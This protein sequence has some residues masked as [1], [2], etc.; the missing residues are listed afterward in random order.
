MTMTMMMTMRLAGDMGRRV[1][2][3]PWWPSQEMMLSAVRTTTTTTSRSVIHP[4]TPYTNTKTPTSTTPN[5]SDTKVASTSAGV[6][7]RRYKE[8]ADPPPSPRDDVSHNRTAAHTTASV[9]LEHCTS[10]TIRRNPMTLLLLLSLLLVWMMGRV[11]HHYHHEITTHAANPPWTVFSVR[12]PR[13]VWLP[14]RNRPASHERLHQLRRPRGN[15]HYDPP[16]IT[17]DPYTAVANDPDDFPIVKYD[18]DD[19]D[20][21]DP[22]IQLIL[23]AQVSLIDLRLDLSELRKWDIHDDDE[24]DNNNDDDDDDHRTTNQ[25]YNGIYGTFCKINMTLYKHNPN[26][27]PMYNDLIRHSPECNLSDNDDDETSHGGLIRNINLRRIVNL[28]RQYDQGVDRKNS[29][30]Q[31]GPT[32]ANQNNHHHQNSRPEHGSSK[33][34]VLNVTSVIFH[35]SRC[36]STLL[37]NILTTMDIAKHR[38]YSEPRPILQAIQTICGEDFTVC[39][40][41]TATAILRDT[42]YIMSRSRRSTELVEERKDASAEEERVFFKFPSIASRNIPVFTKAFPNVPY[43]LLYRNPMEVMVSHFHP[44]VKDSSIRD[45]AVRSTANDIATTPNKPSP[46]IIK[47]LSQRHSPSVSVVDVVQKYNRHSHSNS[48]TSMTTNG[49]IVLAKALKDSDYCAAHL[50]SMTEMMVSSVTS[51]AI[52]MNYRHV[53]PDN[54]YTNVFPKLFWSSPN[55]D[56]NNDT[57]AITETKARVELMASL[58]SKNRFDSSAG[59]MRSGSLDKNSNHSTHTVF[60]TDTDRKHQLASLEI[61]TA[62]TKYLLP[63]YLQL[64]ELAQQQLL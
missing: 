18:L 47:C 40:P 37:T 15:H 62:V 49:P 16:R 53:T 20:V 33:V 14:F 50:A 17:P 56:N 57:H 25:N 61:R 52:V 12:T 6:T 2:A 42:M 7:H 45:G 41:D 44:T 54:L 43:I 31:D 9:L 58:Y 46:L 51:Q 4:P 39:P 59:E 63:S 60:V 29:H 34:N 48:T 11:N 27:Y 23:Q 1:L 10:V 8:E 24:N 30:H 26:L 22:I 28:A 36:G 35:E 64:E 32:R 21:N 55:D 3:A 19:Y 38:V 5:R 13:L